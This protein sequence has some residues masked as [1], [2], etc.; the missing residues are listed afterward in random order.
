MEKVLP[1]IKKDYVTIVF[2]EI[3]N[4]EGLVN[5][6]TGSRLTP[7]LLNWWV[8][9]IGGASGVEGLLSTGPTLSIF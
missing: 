2:Y 1:V 4:L 8:F 6:I 5:R 3:L 7:I 9:P